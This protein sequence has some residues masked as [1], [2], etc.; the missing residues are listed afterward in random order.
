MIYGMSDP[1]GCLTAFARAL[2][3]VDLSGEN[4]LVLLGDYVHGPDGYGVLDAIMKLQE[5]YGSHKIIALRGNHEVFALEGTWPIGETA[6][7]KPYG[8]NRKDDSKYLAWMKTLPLYYVEG[9][10]I[11]VHAGVDE[12]AGEFWQWSTEDF[13]FTSKYPAQTGHFY[14]DMKIVAGHIGTSEISGDPEF[15]DIYF[16][17]ESHYYI[18]GTVLRSG[19]IPVMKVDTENNKYYQVTEVGD[20]PILPYHECN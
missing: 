19:V 9:N 17:G 11:F 1:H 18:D 8:D 15:H 12:E 4:K 13:T 20:W 2:S 16:D 3:F 7:G 6:D 5:K 10:T 14:G